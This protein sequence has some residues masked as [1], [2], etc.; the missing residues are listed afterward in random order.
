V[1]AGKVAF[2][3]ERRFWELDEQ[4]YGGLSWITRDS[5]QVW[6]P[7]A[8]LHQKKGILVAAYIWSET[9]G[10]AFAAKTPAQRV[11][12]TLA[13]L[14]HLHPGGG[15]DLRHGVS[16][17][18]KEQPFSGSGWAEWSAEARC[19]SY[20]A[21]LDGDGPYLFAGEHVSYVTGWQEGGVLSAHYAV[22][23]LGKRAATSAG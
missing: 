8:G 4:I 2:Q 6:Y 15:R 11:E 10:N 14:E 20:Q 12:D 19:A 18:W 1:P 17:S 5:T 3:A 9:E 21:L 13:D 16:V 23:A 7:S 22:A